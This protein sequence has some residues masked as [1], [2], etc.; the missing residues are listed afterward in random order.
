MCCSANVVDRI[1]SGVT[2]DQVPPNRALLVQP[3]SLDGQALIRSIGGF[4]YAYHQGGKAMRG[5]YTDQVNG[6]SLESWFC[7]WDPVP[8]WDKFVGHAMVVFHAMAGVSGGHR[9]TQGMTCEACR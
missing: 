3:H 6:D 1:G 7:Y 9:A 5:S 4:S 8:V 2:V